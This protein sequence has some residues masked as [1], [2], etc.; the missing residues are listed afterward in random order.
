MSLTKLTENLNIHQSLPDKPAQTSTELKELFDRAGNIIK[1]YINNTLT[2]EVDSNLNTKANSSEVSV[3]L[4]RKA[5]KEDTYTKT[6]INTMLDQKILWSGAHY[7]NED[8]IAELNENISDQNKGI[9]LI[10]S[11]YSDGEAKNWGWV[12][13]FVPK[14]MV[15][16]HEGVGHYIIIPDNSYDYGIKASKYV[17]ISDDKIT[18]NVNNQGEH[19]RLNN[20]SAVLRYVI[21]V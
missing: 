12:E 19:G 16:L 17:Y 9:V 10:W 15:E 4:E 13:Y 3:S 2:S 21:G 11:E 18:G 6:E 8:Q 1:Q 5:D 14:K 20:S 7:M